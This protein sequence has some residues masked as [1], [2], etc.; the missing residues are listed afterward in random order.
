MVQQACVR[1]APRIS[2]GIV[3]LPR[4]L[5]NLP[6]RTRLYVGLTFLAWGSIGLVLSNL[7]E[8]KL[9]LEPTPSD[10]QDLDELLPRIE[11]VERKK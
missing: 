10:Q 4:S 7:A 3:P 8:R 6:P 5:R 9:G 11:V 2:R 1:S